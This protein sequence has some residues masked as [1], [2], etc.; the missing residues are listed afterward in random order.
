[1]K[2]VGGELELFQHARNWKR[3]FAGHLKPFVRGRVLDVGC[4][5]G[6]NA[7]YLLSDRVRSYTFLEPDPDLLAMVATHVRSPFLVNA[8]RINGRAEDLRGRRFDTILYIDVIE[9]I[10]D[11]KGELL[12]AYELLE[13]GGHLL[14]LLPACNFLFSPFD[15]A[16]G[17]HRR[18]NRSM[19]RSELPAGLQPVKTFYLDSLGYFLSLVNK[20]LLRRE[21]PTPSQIRFWDRTVVPCSRVFD[22]V[23]MHAFGR[24]LIC[25]ARK[26]ER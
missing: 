19:L 12:R 25:F 18:Y 8:E 4:G 3:Y 15:R 14:I 9:H 16:V 1:M 21:L 11:S 20:M 13:P 22:N 7:E 26:P 17:H 5:T 23:F 2:Y 24:S 6:V 10:E